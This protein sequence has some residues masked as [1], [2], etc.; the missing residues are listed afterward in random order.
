MGGV[1]V[2]T[3]RAGA[4]AGKSRSA[5]VL[6]VDCKHLLQTDQRVYFQGMLCYPESGETERESNRN[7]YTHAQT[8]RE[9]GTEA[10]AEAAAEEETETTATAT[11]TLTHTL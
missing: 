5:C 10:E 3:E 6:L 9:A 7:A 2:Y 4:C 8:V 1:D 11:E